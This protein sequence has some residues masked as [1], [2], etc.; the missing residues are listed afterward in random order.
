MPHCLQDIRRQAG[1]SKQW[2]HKQDG[3]LHKLVHHY[4]IHIRLYCF[5]LTFV[6][7]EMFEHCNEIFLV[8][9]YFLSLTI[10]WVSTIRWKRLYLSWSLAVS[11]LKRIFT[12]WVQLKITTVSPLTQNGRVLTKRALK[13][14]WKSYVLCSLKF[15]MSTILKIFILF[16]VEINNENNKFSEIFR[17]LQWEYKEKEILCINTRYIFLLHTSRFD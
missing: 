5:Y 7:L 15:F 13:K 4:D 6:T 12:R 2:Q 17:S 10:F 9:T 16:K 8:T 14:A 3:Y 11:L 1:L